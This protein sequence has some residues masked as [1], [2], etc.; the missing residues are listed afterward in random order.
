MHMAGPG[1][2]GATGPVLRLGQ[3]F[4]SKGQWGLSVW[5]GKRP[6][7][8][9]MTLGRREPRQTAAISRRKV[10]RQEVAAREKGQLL[11][12][13]GGSRSLVP[14]TQWQHGCHAT[15]PRTMRVHAG[16]GSTHPPTT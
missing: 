1:A 4:S 12:S 8:E 16:R 6:Q 10:M 7:A 2:G 9:G 13:L 15:Q 11:I 3:H 5:T 14:A